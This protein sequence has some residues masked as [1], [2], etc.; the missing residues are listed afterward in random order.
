MMKKH[1]KNKEERTLAD[2]S[3]SSLIKVWYICEQSSLRRNYGGQKLRKE[4]QPIRPEGRQ[5]D[6][7]YI[8][9]L[10]VL[11]GRQVDLVILHT[12]QCAA[13]QPIEE[14]NERA[15]NG[16]IKGA[17]EGTSGVAADNIA[18]DRGM[19]N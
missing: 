1:R 6:L 19:T 13:Q 16:L 14:S 5:T 12:P 9:R 4:G 8:T 10:R 18:C 7:L 11:E 2:C 15:R 3:S 17:I